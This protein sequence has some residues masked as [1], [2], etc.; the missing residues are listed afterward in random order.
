[1]LRTTPSLLALVLLAAFARARGVANAGRAVI[2][3]FRA[4][5]I[6]RK[7]CSDCH[8]GKP[9]VGQSKLNVMDFGNSQPTGRF[10]RSSPAGRSQI[11]ELIKD[12][13]M[14]RRPIALGRTPQRS[15]CWRSGSRRSASAF[16]TRFNDRYTLD[17]LADDLAGVDAKDKFVRYASFVHLIRD[18]EPLRDLVAEERKL[19]EAFALASP[20]AAVTITPVNPTATLYRIELPRIGWGKQEL[21]RKMDRLKEGDVYPLRPF[22]LIHMEYPIRG[23]D[24]S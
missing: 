1:M 16:P 24:R 15:R 2:L 8:T 14:P 5:G 12:G 22:D 18:G 20:G 10:T 3:P 19:R 11:L 7:Y 6:L 13:S 17:S 4:Q 9:D 21:F 23:D